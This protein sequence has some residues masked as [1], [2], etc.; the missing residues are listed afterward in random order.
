[1]R[2]DGDLKKQTRVNSS[3]EWNE[4]WNPI[5]RRFGETHPVRTEY[6]CLHYHSITRAGRQPSSQGRQLGND[7]VVRG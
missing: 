1:M 6:K 5:T 4:R 7:S 2:L 3:L